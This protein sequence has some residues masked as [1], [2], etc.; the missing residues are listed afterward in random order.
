MVAKV[1]ALVCDLLSN[2]RRATGTLPAAVDLFNRVNEALTQT[3]P[4]SGARVIG[5]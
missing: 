2:A 4:I 5:D 3:G 1:P